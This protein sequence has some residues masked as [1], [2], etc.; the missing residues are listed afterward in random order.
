ML[1]SGTFASGV[2]LAVET[3][4]PSLWVMTAGT[5]LFGLGFGALDAAL[6]AHA[7]RHFG[8]RR[9]NWMHAWYGL[10]ATISPLLATALLGGGAGWRWIYGSLAVV[11]GA[12]AGV[13][14]VTRGAWR[15][16]PPP[17][18]EPSPPTE[19]PPPPRESEPGPLGNVG[20]AGSSP[21]PGPRA[22]DVLATSAFAAVE[23]GIESGAGIWA[24]VFLTAGQGLSDQA[25]GVTVA[26]YWATMFAGRAVLGPV[27]ERLGPARV[28][29]G[30]VIGVT[31]SAALMTVPGPRALAVAALL[32]LGL[33]AAPLFPL[34]TLLTGRRTDAA[35]RTPDGEPA[36][37]QPT[38]SEPAASQRASQPAAGRV[39]LLV[40]ASAAG[41]A[42][43]PAGIGLAIG[44]FQAGVLGPALLV[45]SVAMCALCGATVRGR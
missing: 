13:F 14:T 28:L 11:A 15:A 35:G 20:P 12:M 18:G 31:L 17:P 39:G 24:Y 4:A 10:G 23:A 16:S 36:A 34:L 2:A 27:A 9:I 45:L 40:A 5:V 25:A 42:A 6:N 44:A 32:S 1:A 26:A 43:L 22:A 3:V 30:A 21:G 29:A 19:P 8:A 41:N 7:A 37:S 33:A 38:A